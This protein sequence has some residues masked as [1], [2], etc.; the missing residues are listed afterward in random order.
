[1]KKSAQTLFRHTQIHGRKDIEFSKL[2][3]IGKSENLFYFYL[4][5]GNGTGHTTV[6]LNEINIFFEKG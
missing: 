6:V 2:L 5:C 1:M 4:G 3:W